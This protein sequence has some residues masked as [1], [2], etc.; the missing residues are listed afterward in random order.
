LSL[1]QYNTAATDSNRTM[2]I[3]ILPCKQAQKMDLATSPLLNNC[4]RN[5]VGGVGYH[6]SSESGDAVTSTP[7]DFGQTRGKFFR[8]VLN[9]GP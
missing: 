3:T 1:V 7:F 8:P 4:S 2:R 5:W 9:F 6:E